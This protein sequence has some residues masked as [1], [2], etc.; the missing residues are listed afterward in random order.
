MEGI[1]ALITT[2]WYVAMP[3]HKDIGVAFFTDGIILEP[4]SNHLLGNTNPVLVISLEPNGLFI[5]RN[6]LPG[7]PAPFEVVAEMIQKLLCP[8]QRLL[9]NCS[10]GLGVGFI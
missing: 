1:Q 7:I 2:S 4:I 3:E 9:I 5:Y 6:I 10:G 8:E